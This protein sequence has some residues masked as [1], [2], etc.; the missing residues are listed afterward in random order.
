MKTVEILLYTLRP[1]TG[2]EFHQIMHDVSVPLHRS[3]GMD[4]VAY[5]NSLHDADSYYLIRVYDDL[6]HLTMSQDEFYQSAA[7]RNGPREAIIGQIAT[8][9]KSVVTLS[10]IAV[11]HLRRASKMED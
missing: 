8:S 3:V 5:G 2:H 7:W 4:V 6:N 1:G 10:N 11:D 9:T